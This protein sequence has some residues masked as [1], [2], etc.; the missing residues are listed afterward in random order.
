VIRSPRA[1]RSQSSVYVCAQNL[2]PRT[3]TATSIVSLTSRSLL[4]S[5]WNNTTPATEAMSNF[6]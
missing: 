6:G 4:E 5:N 3:A 1:V 2:R